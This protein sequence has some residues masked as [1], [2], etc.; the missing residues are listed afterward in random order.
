MGAT[1]DQEFALDFLDI[2]ADRWLEE[3]GEY[4][5]R[6]DDITFIPSLAQIS[7]KWIA[8]TAR[9][10][11]RQWPPNPPRVQ[12]YVRTND[13]TL[14][15]FEGSRIELREALNNIVHGDP[16]R[17]LVS[18]GNL[19][20]GFRNPQPGNNGWEHAWFSAKEVLSAVRTVIYA[21]PWPSNEDKARIL[22]IFD[23]L[24]R[25]N[26]MPRR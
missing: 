19:Y 17:V 5:V 3:P 7:L 11:R 26:F 16:F 12:R 10:Q 20:L 14:E 6:D 15:G 4:P 13:D 1:P 8:G 22:A 9:D 21:A 25:D 23:N 18:D 2:L 24:C